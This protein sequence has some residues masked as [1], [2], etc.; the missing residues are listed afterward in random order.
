MPESDGTTHTGIA[1]DDPA[2][3]RPPL[4]RYDALLAVIPV[5]FAAALLVAQLFPVSPHRALLGASIVGVL[6]IGDGLFRNPPRP[7]PAA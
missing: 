4:T 6:A 1:S 3:G 7:T 2:E 5:A